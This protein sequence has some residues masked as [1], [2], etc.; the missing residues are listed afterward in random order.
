MS[1]TLALVGYFFLSLVT[2][3]D[4]FIITNERVK[5]VKVAFYSS[6]MLLPIFLLVPFGVVI[7]RGADWLMA[8]ASGGTFVLALWTT[9]LSFEKSEVSH[10]GPLIGAAIP[11]FVIVLNRFFLHEII[12]AGQYAAIALLVI[13]SLII[14]QK[15]S[16]F[17]KTRQ[18]GWQAGVVLAIAAGLLFAISNI[19]A[20][21]L[22]DQYGF[23]SGL[24]WSRG[25]SGLFGLCL[26]LWPGAWRLIFSSS[27]NS[28]RSQVWL[29]LQT[30][31]IVVDKVLSLGGNF[32]VQY[33]TAIG[34]VALVNALSGVQYGLLIIL[35]A[36]L[37]R[38][39]PR[40][41]KEVYEPGEMQQEI[42]AVII[43]SIGL[44]VLLFGVH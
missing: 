8:L 27:K 7:L 10:S 34:S 26:L 42:V 4:K 16:F 41:F 6:V 22:Y 44:A 31:V 24:V 35:V 43:I 36:I 39:M 1:I 37:S 9:Y 29:T 38:F 32:L 17:K 25:T 3:L 20:K 13:G 33:A 23:F 5:P 18:V 40:L 19:T 2:L 12:T 30:K 21:Y 15:K 14:S 28:N 11:F